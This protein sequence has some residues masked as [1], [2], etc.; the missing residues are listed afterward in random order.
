MNWEMIDI[1]KS[2][3]FGRIPTGTI[4]TDVQ[5]DTGENLSGYVNKLIIDGYIRAGSDGMDRTVLGLTKLGES[6]LKNEGQ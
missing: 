5:S 6:I 3:K 4:I 1:L 2:I